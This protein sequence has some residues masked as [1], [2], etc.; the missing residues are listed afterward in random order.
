MKAIIVQRFA[1]AVIIA[2]AHLVT[3]L[4]AGLIGPDQALI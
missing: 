1:V 3:A 4:V 2:T